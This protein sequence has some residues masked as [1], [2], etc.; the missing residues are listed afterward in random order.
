M[1]TFEKDLL[2]VRPALH[3]FAMKLSKNSATAEDL[4]QE[5]MYRALSKRH[6]FD[7]DNIT[8]WTFVILRNLFYTMHRV[9]YREVEDPEGLIAA[10]LAGPDDQHVKLETDEMMT[11]LAG[12]PATY[13]KTVS[14]I[15]LGD[16]YRQI[17]AADCVP[18]GT[19]KS[20]T[21][22]AREM[23]KELA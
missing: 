8:A 2:G 7:G 15:A 13:R 14:R 17:A 20:R 12:L 19:V 16:T 3:K 22:R 10:K 11:A 4:V 23:L 1:D 9:K 18:V 5:T 21:F 6:Q